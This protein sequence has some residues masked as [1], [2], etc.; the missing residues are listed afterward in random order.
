M[1]KV[2]LAIISVLLLITIGLMVFLFQ[3]E[4]GDTEVIDESSSISTEQERPPAMMK[5]PAGESFVTHVYS[6][7]IGEV[8]VQVTLPSEP[9]YKKEGAPVVVEIKAF[10]TGANGFDKKM[11][12]MTEY[13]FIHVSYLWP[14]KSEPTGERSEGVFDYGGEDSIQA[15]SDIVAFASGSGKNVDGYM[16]HEMIQIQPMYSNSGLHAFSHPGIA[17]INTMALYRDKLPNVSWLVGR[18]NPTDDIF[19]SVELGYWED[20][21]RHLNPLYTYEENYDPQ[22]IEI[23]YSSAR[24]DQETDRA[25][26]DLNGSGILDESDHALGSRIPTVY[27]KRYYSI[28]MLRA[29]ESNGLIQEGWPDDLAS[30][31]DAERLWPFRTSID[32]FPLLSPDL[33]VITVFASEQHVQGAPDAP[34][35]HQAYDGYKEAGVWSRLNPDSAYLEAIAARP[36]SG[37]VERDANT[38]PIDWSNA[39]DEWGYKAFAGSQ[40]FVPYAAMLEL[41]DRTWNDN[42]GA[43]LTDVLYEIGS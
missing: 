33:H 42:W 30:A 28:E 32:N 7:D 21:M 4:N 19:S 17:M 20:D 9:R 41:A 16:L 27:D 37:Y 13:G 5:I 34:S 26:F 8:A 36:P 38:E 12:G 14:G 15:L 24:Y 18:E 6:Q 22:Q 25:Y 31:A 23:D 39:G 10:F 35:I 40:N 2:L 1:N 29:L 3:L 11:V 43:D